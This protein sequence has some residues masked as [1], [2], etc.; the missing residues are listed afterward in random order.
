[1]KKKIG[2]QIMKNN[3][4][5][6]DIL[7]IGLGAAGGVLFG[8][9]AEAGFDVTGIDA[10]P[11]WE[12]EKDFVSDERE[13]EKL[14]W[15]DPRISDGDNPL[16]VGAGT[17][18]KGVGGGTVHY[19]MMSLRLHPSDF[20]IKSRDGVG[21]DW[22]INYDDL[23]P[24]YTEIEQELPVAGGEFPWIRQSKPYPQ[25]AHRLSCVDQKFKLGAE[26]LGIRVSPCPLALITEPMTG[27]Q[28]CINRGFCEQGCKPKAKSSTLITYIPRGQKSGGKIISEAM[29]KKIN[30]D[31]T[32]KKVGSVVYVKDKKEYQ[33]ECNTLI[34]SAF[35]IETPRLLLN[36]KSDSFPDGLANNSGA[37]GK[38][39]MAHSD[40]VVY[41]KFAEPLRIYRNPPITSLTQDFYET[42]PKND[43]VRGFSIAPYSG[44]PIGFALGAMAGRPDLWGKKLRDFMKEYNFWLQLGIIGEVLPHENNRV[45]L[46]SEKDD[47][48]LPITKTFFSI[49]ENEREMIK[50][51]YRK[52]EEIM[53]AAGAL[54]M[55]RSPLFVHLMGTTRMG[56]DPKNSVVDK[57]LKAHDLENLYVCGASVFPTSGAVNPTL[58]I[59][60]LSARLANHL[61][62]MRGK[63][64]L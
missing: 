4:E 18:G 56:D 34:L 31:K 36:N 53:R 1:M 33:I 52:M 17:S 21:V 42:D 26:K 39:L 10:G 57:N 8:K 7:L 43:F 46:A 3:F 59:Q 22:P 28:P 51:G 29:V 9:L 54:E 48:G 13:M 12:T 58:T 35:A 55:F 20:Q 32:G 62:E 49:G 63:K 41:A 11:H 2:N 15:N 37:V 5:K 47:Y 60:A 64:I 16:D 44:R 25:K 38:Y 50:A 40:H 45:E 30:L 27:R 24:Y 6:T 19:T 61:I 14:K 23:E